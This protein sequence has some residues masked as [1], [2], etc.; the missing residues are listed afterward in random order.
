MTL[1][2]KLNNDVKSLFEF[3][4]FCILSVFK[5]FK[6]RN[7]RNESLASDYFAILLWLKTLM[8]LGFLRAVIP[9]GLLSTPWTRYSF[10]LM[11]IVIFF[12]WHSF[13][14]S[15][16]VKGGRYAWILEYHELRFANSR[17]LP[18]GIG[19]LYALLTFAAFILV[20]S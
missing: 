19:A 20:I 4:Y 10:M 11:L 9:K 15:Y 12:A 7:V 14:K 2:Y 17:W 6:R 16:F 18:I 5:A 13:C 8:I 1:G 3:L